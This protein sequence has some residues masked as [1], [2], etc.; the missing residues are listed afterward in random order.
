MWLTYLLAI[1]FSF[2]AYFLAQAIGLSGGLVLVLTFVGAIVG[3]A[4]GSALRG[5]PPSRGRD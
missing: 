5:R 3:A 4:V 1:A 2:G